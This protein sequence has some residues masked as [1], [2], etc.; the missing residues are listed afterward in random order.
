MNDASQSQ[1]LQG[2]PY[3]E[4]PPYSDYSS[5]F[6]FTGAVDISIEKK[7]QCMQLLIAR[8][9]NNNKALWCCIIDAACLGNVVI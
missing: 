3:K 4:S 8:V 9:W 1:V 2:R 5:S 6:L 7:K